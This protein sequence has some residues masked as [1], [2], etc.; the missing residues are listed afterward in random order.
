MLTSFLFLI[1]TG[2][3]FFLKF[4]NIELVAFF[5]IDCAG[6]YINLFNLETSS[7]CGGYSWGCC[8]DA[9]LVELVQYCCRRCCGFGGYAVGGSDCCLAVTVWRAVAGDPVAP[10]WQLCAMALVLLPTLL[11]GM[12]NAGARCKSRP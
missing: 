1:L 11:A 7:G 5:F 12:G 9:V 6:N 3:F 8:L 4:H 2:V 10:C